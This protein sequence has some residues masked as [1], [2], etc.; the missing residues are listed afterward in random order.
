MSMLL[1]TMTNN[2]S[3]NNNSGTGTKI[4]DAEIV[5]TMTPYPEAQGGVL[6]GIFRIL[7]DDTRLR[8]LFYLQHKPEI[9]VRTFCELLG[10]SQP[11]VSH[12]L[13]MLKEAG[14]IDSRRDGKNNFYHFVPGKARDYLDSFFGKPDLTPIRLVVADSLLTF[15]RNAKAE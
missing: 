11:A 9:N 13:A 15:E 5:A 6:A 3:T 4:S 8:I 12:H 1:P 7:G 2:N 14:L 10:Q